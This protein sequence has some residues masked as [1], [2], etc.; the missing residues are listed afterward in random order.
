MKT[1]FLIIIAFVLILPVYIVHA[2]TSNEYT[3]AKLEWSQHNF[4]I[5]NGTGTAKIILTDFDVPNIP[6]YIDKVTVFVYSDSF[7]EGI[8][9][10]LYETEKNSGIFERTFSLSDTRSAPSV[11]Y[12]REGDTAIV[13]YLDD[14][15]PT[16]H[17]LSE[18]QLRETTLIGL[19]GHPIERLPATNPRIV[20]LDGDRLDF[21]ILGQQILLQSDIANPQDILQN[22]IW[23]AQ[24]ID[25][26][27][28]IES[29]SWIN[30]TIN[31]QSSFS[32]STS[33]IPTTAGEY[34][35]TF[36]V[37]ES[38]DN[39]TALSPPVEL[40]FTVLDEP[41]SKSE[42]YDIEIIGLKNQYKIGEK[43][44]FTFIISGY[45]YACANYDAKYHD[46]NGNVMVMGAEVLCEAKQRM[47]T[48]E[49]NHAERKEM[50]GDIGIKKSGTYSVTVTFEKPN[51][52]FPTSVTK[53]FEVVE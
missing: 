12:A 52:Y 1:K 35:T 39:P 22:F 41:E 13:K 9:L 32:P 47:N 53:T 28:R 48:F 21:P 4:G 37:W 20:N 26:Q 23:L 8:A 34:R 40:E 27:K 24:T 7:P 46:E 18:I 25:S 17:E 11:L 43:Y 3:E 19:L 2:E 45:G 15:L 42:H 36:F 49:I 38:I 50:I 29:L 14:T 51:P 16:D 31:P 6:T 30:G 5:I 33:W 10:T 44:S